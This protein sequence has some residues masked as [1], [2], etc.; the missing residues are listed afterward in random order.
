MTHVVSGKLRKQPFVKP[1][2]GQDGQSTMYIIELAEVIKDYR[3]EEKTYTNYKAMF[4]AKTQGA[5]DFYSKAFEEGSFVTVASEK[6]KAELFQAD[7]GVTYVTMI[8][9][10]P[11]LEG[12][13]PVSEMTGSQSQSR[14]QQHGGWGQPQQPQQQQTQS[15]SQPQ[16][17]YSDD[18]TPP[19]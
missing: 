10:N 8:M 19:F 11:R 18:D 1:G 3:T 7:S 2:V 16:Y 9:E 14:Q 15:Q 6:L 4:F 13:L 5:N 17:N 12:A